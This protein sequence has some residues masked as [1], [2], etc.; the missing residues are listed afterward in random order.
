M[1]SARALQDR[2]GVSPNGSATATRT[3][4]GRQP[5]DDAR[6]KAVMPPGSCVFFVGTLWH[7]D[8]ANA[9]ANAYL[10]ATV[11]C[12]HRTLPDR[13]PSSCPSGRD[14]PAERRGGKFS[15]RRTAG[16]SRQ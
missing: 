2:V 9:S 12:R 11:W 4:D 7:G 8:G 6:V 16:A 1:T 15:D 13:T 14:A 10:T 3:P 5:T